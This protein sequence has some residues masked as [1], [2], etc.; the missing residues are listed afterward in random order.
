M[1]R[2]E[3]YVQVL[4]PSGE[5]V[6]PFFSPEDT[7]YLV[8]L[9][10]NELAELVNKYPDRFVGAVAAL[11]MNNMDAALKEIDRAIN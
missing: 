3:E 11:P 9:F 1:D 10:N 7:A 5:I 2:Y 8:K 4:V 6:E